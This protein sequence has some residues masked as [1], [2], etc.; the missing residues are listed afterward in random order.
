MSG[1]WWER[2]DPQVAGE[3]APAGTVAP[4]SLDGTLAPLAGSG[5]TAL[6]KHAIP[7]G[8]PVN[9]V[10]SSLSTNLAGANNDLVF[11]AVTKGVAGDSITIAYVDPAVETPTESVAVVGTAIAVTLRSVSSVLSTAAQVKAAIDATPAAAA[12]VTVANKAANDGTGSVIAMAATAL[13]G[14]VNG[15]VGVAGEALRDADYLY[16]AT[17]TNT[18]SGANWRRVSLGS[19]Y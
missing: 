9:A 2:G 16:V 10:A 17:A 14:G 3:T 15:T 6:H 19:V 8:T 11:T 5:F 4:A 12:L 1:S 7:T 18:I 13:A